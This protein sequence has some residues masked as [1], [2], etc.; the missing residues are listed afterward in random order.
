MAFSSH[1]WSHNSF[2]PSEIF[3]VVY[4]FPFVL[5]YFPAIVL[6]NVWIYILGKMKVEELSTWFWR[7]HKPQKICFKFKWCKLD[8]SVVEI[9]HCCPFSFSLTM[10]S[11]TDVLKIKVFKSNRWSCIGFFADWRSLLS[12]RG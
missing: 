1:T 5:L 6:S 2:H 9:L 7:S 8:S 12:V 4:V 10:A 11:C 3:I